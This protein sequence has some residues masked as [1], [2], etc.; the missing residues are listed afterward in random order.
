MQARIIQSSV[1]G[2]S[3]TGPNVNETK[4]DLRYDVKYNALGTFLFW[5]IRVLPFT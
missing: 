2:D 1:Y 5:Q 4:N 3:I